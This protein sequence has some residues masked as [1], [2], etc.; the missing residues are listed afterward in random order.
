[1]PPKSERRQQTRKQPLLG[2]VNHQPCHLVSI[3]VGKTPSVNEAIVP[4]TPCLDRWRARAS[5]LL[6]LFVGGR[7]FPRHPRS[8]SLTSTSSFKPTLLKTTLPS[9]PRPTRATWSVCTPGRRAG[10]RLR[11]CG[12]GNWS[13]TSRLSGAGEE[14]PTPRAP[15]YVVSSVSPRC[16]AH[17]P[18]QRPRTKCSRTICHTC[19]WRLP[20]PMKKA[21]LR[22]LR[23]ETLADLSPTAL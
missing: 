13:G 9:C 3:L 11:A 12:G 21:Y 6:R 14:V 15:E 4:T 1:M 19:A 7:P 22:L 17:G 5:Y 8:A 18:G 20:L 16:N 23:F 2:L 10:V